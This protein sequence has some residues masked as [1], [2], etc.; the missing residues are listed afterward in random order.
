MDQGFVR[1][2][3]ALVP[4]SCEPYIF[5]LRCMSE[6]L[7]WSNSYVLHGKILTARKAHEELKGTQCIL[8]ALYELSS[9]SA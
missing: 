5:V 2:I 1:E 9:S 3:D 7:L 8:Y 6:V 4:L